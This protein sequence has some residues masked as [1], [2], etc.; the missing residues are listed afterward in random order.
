MLTKT[1][2]LLPKLLGLAMTV[3]IIIAT[4]LTFKTFNG[5]F[6][7]TIT[8]S[9]SVGQAGDSLEAGDIVTY[10]SVIVGEVKSFRVTASTGATQ[11]TLRLSRPKAN[12]VPANVTAIAVPASLFGNTKIQLV[13]PTEPAPGSLHDGS[14]IRA[15]TS[16]GAEGLQTALSQLYDL[17]TVVHPAELNNALT[18]LASAVQGRG[19]DIGKLIDKLDAY[20]KTLNPMIPGIVQTIR[21]LATV[22]TSAASNAPDI[23]QT[24]S[25]GLTPAAAIIR[26][27]QAIGEL[28]TF[29]P[30]LLDNATMLIH[31]VGNNFVTV[32][33]NGGPLAS[34]M[35][36]R[37]AA[38]GDT[39]IGFR[40][41][42]DAFASA[43]HGGKFQINGVV[44]GVNAA[45]LVPLLL[46]QTTHVIDRA[47]D[48]R[49]YTTAQCPQ[50]PGAQGRNC[51]GDSVQTNAAVMLTGGTNTSGRLGAVGSAGEI[52]AV[53][54]VV[55][56][57]TA[58]P[59]DN[60]PAAIDL[61]MG[62]LLRGTTT[63]IP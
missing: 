44:T 41:V 9:A 26:Q 48:P 10:R 61:I 50:Y 8:V 52:Q 33:I 24:L 42:A 3:L 57:M 55:S 15:D 12:V 35:A 14:Q 30:T 16:P 23:L 19:D 34:A 1:T 32:V 59:V 21:S 2:G 38:L 37:P 58:V 11:L 5:D 36:Q 27:Q 62:P 53:E 39:V 25:N 20:L 17:L 28:F 56:A 54:A 45:A 60:V 22:A 51:A 18:A 49:V 4:V 47:T 31:N 13:D 7:D 40:N 63:V 46:G 43:L 6:G 29:A